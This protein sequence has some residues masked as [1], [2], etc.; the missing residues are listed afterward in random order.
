MSR[1]NRAVHSQMQP[2]FP[3]TQGGLVGVSLTCLVLPEQMSI[4][5][6]ER[7]N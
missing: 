4:V 7:W 3:H 5:A 1:A 6:G 2:I